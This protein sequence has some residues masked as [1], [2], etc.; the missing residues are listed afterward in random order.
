MFE[1]LADALMSD[2]DGK[3][4]L[5]NLGMQTLRSM[6]GN[7]TEA[8]IPIPNAVKPII[9]LATGVS[10]F[11]GR[12]IVDER[13]ARLDKAQQ[14]RDK[15]PEVLK[16]AGPALE[17]FNLSPAQVEHVIRGYTGSIGVGLL[18]VLNPLLSS[19][20]EAGPVEKPLSELPILGAFFQ[21]NDAGRVINDAY[22]TAEELMRRQ[23]T[24][25]KLITDGEYEKAQKYLKENMVGVS[26]ASYAGSFRQ[27]MGEIT[28]TERAIKAL[29]ESSMS[30]EEKRERLLELKQLKN[31]LAE[32][33]T[34][35]RK[36]IERQAARP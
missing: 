36:Q 2:Q 16:A 22:D 8:G 19:G 26:L 23:A 12:D 11:T 6:P 5:K 10:F 30:A 13:L 35:T 7:V 3:K 24:Y 1:G 14:F 25:K 33:F 9:E 34:E 21:P 31:R 28:K 29:P 15:T 32:Q 4:I 27:Q 17:M 20:K 18:S